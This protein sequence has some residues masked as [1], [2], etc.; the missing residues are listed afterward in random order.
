MNRWFALAVLAGAA[1]VLGGPSSAQ[2]ARTV[3]MRVQDQRAKGVRNDITVP[4]LTSWYTTILPGTYVAP[5]IYASPNVDSLNYP[6]AMPVFNL[7]YYGSRQGFGD[8][9]DGAKPR[10]RTP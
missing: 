9:S 1:I 10:V 2:A 6:Q 5:R 3:S 8:R 7:I 4:Y